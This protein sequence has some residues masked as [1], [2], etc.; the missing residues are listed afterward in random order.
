MQPF[1][2]NQVP[3]LSA[4]ARN[5]AIS[6]AWY[7]S[8]PRNTWPNRSFFHAASNGNV[9]NGTAP[10]PMAWNVPSIFNVLEAMGVNWR[11]YTDTV[12]TPS[13]T[14]LMSPQLWPYALTRISHFDA[15]VRLRL[16]LASAIFIPRAQF[17]RQA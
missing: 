1:S 10:D 11:I 2:A 8:V 3:V 4:L 9:V 16:R 7:S 6:D 15:P 12:V 14:G 17:C 5:F 13:L